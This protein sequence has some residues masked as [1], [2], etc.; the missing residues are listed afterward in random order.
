MP[1]EITFIFKYFSKEEKYVEISK[2][3]IAILKQDDNTIEVFKS[4]K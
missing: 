1:T 3:L 2:K 4:F